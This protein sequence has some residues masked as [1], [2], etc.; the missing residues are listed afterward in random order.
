M[1][2]R[3]IPVLLLLGLLGLLGS[4]DT[5]AAGPKRYWVGG[6][7]GIGLGDIEFVSVEPIFGYAFNEKTS[8]GVRLVFRYTNDTRGVEDTSS[9]DWGGSL[10]GRYLIKAGIF[11]QL[12]YEYLNYEFNTIGGSSDE[13]FQSVLGGFGFQRPIG[14]NAAFFALGLYN[15]SYDSDE[16]V[17]PYDGPWI[18]RAGVSFGF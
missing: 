15:F 4:S 9:T 6:G 7:I 17:S 5:M 14:S 12:E 1:L 18:F 3:T 8:A 13:S 16:L 11:A 2:R 10:W